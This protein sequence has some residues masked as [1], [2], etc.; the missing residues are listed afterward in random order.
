LDEHFIAPTARRRIG[1]SPRGANGQLSWSLDS[2]ANLAVTKD[3][4]CRLLR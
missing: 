3:R 4:L 1:H 2:A